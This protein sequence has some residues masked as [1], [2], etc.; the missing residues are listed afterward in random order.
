[1]F[2]ASFNAWSTAAVAFGRLGARSVR[3][4][5]DRRGRD[6]RRR[7]LAT[8]AHHARR[9][10]RRTDLPSLGGSR[11]QFAETSAAVS[12]ERAWNVWGA[13]KLIAPR[14]AARVAGLLL[15]GR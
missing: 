3:Q 13:V 15:W 11:R 14:S 12:G 2:Y 10:V 1:M 7:L 5:F 6:R 4:N 8:L 9:L